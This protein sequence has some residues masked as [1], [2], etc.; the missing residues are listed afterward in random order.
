LRSDSLRTEVRMVRRVL[1]DLY[2][3]F[4][5][6]FCAFLVALFVIC[7]TLQVFFRFVMGASLTWSE[8]LSRFAFIWAIYVGASMA[9]KQQQHI[10]VTA[11]YYLLPRGLRFPVWMLSDLVWVVF[12]I[13]FAIQGIELVHHAIQFPEITPAL[14]WH[15]FWVYAIIPAGFI[16]MTLRTIQLYYRS[17]KD[18][19]WR[20][21][22]KIGEG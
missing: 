4:E 13:L 9:V 5:K 10:R 11:Q 3:N 17:F 16:L 20:K 14:G 8:E 18:G 6:Y 22:V 19:T 2:E 21:L 12:N 1:R 15:A 7:L